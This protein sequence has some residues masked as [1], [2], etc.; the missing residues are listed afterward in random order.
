MWRKASTAIPCNPER[1][2]RTEYSDLLSLAA[3]ML[4]RA[5]TLRSQFVV[6]V[7]KPGRWWHKTLPHSFHFSRDCAYIRNGRTITTLASRR[8]LR[9]QGADS[10]SFLQGLITNDVSVLRGNSRILEGE[11][12]QSRASDDNNGRPKLLYTYF[13]NHKGRAI[14]DSFIKLES[15]DNGTDPSFLLD[16]RDDAY[17]TLSRLLKMHCLRSKVK[18]KEEKNMKICVHGP[19]N[20]NTDGSD[21]GDDLSR[22]AEI[23]HPDPRSSI[24]GL[25]GFIPNELVNAGAENNVSEW[26][27]NFFLRLQGVP[28]GTDMNGLIPLECNLDSLNGVSF[29][30]GCYVG[31]ELTARTHFTGLVRKLC[32]PVYFKLSGGNDA[33]SNGVKFPTS[34]PDI[35]STLAAFNREKSASQLTHFE[36]VSSETSSKKKSLKLL[37]NGK[38]VGKLVL[39]PLQ[40]PADY[41]MEANIADFPPI[42]IA[43]I[44]IDVASDPDHKIFLEANDSVD[45]CGELEVVPFKPA[46]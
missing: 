36:L 16:C 26:T 31:Q 43:L 13:L 34:F 29:D 38:R 1:H 42:G 15:H 14:C 24:F 40:P 33:T 19:W 11:T 22:V 32:Y 39:P 18:I 30:K 6:S 37:S 46:W 27:Y 45:I 28:E 21:Q 20:A 25:R 3:A 35:S 12:A 8:I 10:E 41:E 44:R 2:C 4:R 17:P 5:A 23:L 7:A 9:V